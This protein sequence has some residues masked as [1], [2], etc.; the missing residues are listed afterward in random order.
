VPRRRLIAAAVLGE[1]C[2]E[3]KKEDA[4]MY[5]AAHA[6]NATRF[7]LPVITDRDA[8]RIR[9]LPGRLEFGHHPGPLSRLLELVSTEA[10]IV[11]SAKVGA[12]I[13]TLGSTVAFRDEHTDTEHVATV[14][15]PREAAPAQRR[16]SVLS[17][18]GM[19][20]LGRRIGTLIECAMPDGTQRSLR[21]LQ[22]HYQPEAAGR[23]ER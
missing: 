6:A 1:N 3:I 20:L 19:A 21:L 12:D 15:D 18:V 7:D 22:L 4:T 23:D 8:A 9:E 17:P 16:I 5:A 13:V 2:F 11:P 14:V 10:E